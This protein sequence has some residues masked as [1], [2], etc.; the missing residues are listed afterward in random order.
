MNFELNFVG[1][2]PETLELDPIRRTVLIL[3]QSEP[4]WLGS[5]V[6]NVKLVDDVTIQA[7][8]KDYSGNDYAT[9][10]LS[11]SYIEGEGSSAVV[12]K[13]LPGRIELAEL[14]DI[15][16]SLETA[17]RQAESAGI[18]QSEEVA[19]LVLHGILHIHGFDHGD[20]D[21][22]RTVD[23]MQKMILEQA[24]V[25]YRDFNWV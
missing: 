2:I 19:T 6:V 18:T 3:I 7:F 22:K 25:R 4:K 10:V 1:D 5:G 9:D 8:N 20:V 21:T 23:R 24:G 12:F 15:I 16:I 17:Q 11:F 13:N 14:G